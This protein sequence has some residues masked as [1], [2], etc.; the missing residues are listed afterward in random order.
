M[1]NGC[2]MQTYIGIDNNEVVGLFYVDERKMVLSV[3]WS[4]KIASYSDEP[5]VGNTLFIVYYRSIFKANF[6]FVINID[7][8][9][10]A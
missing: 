5:D 7:V 4:R 10:E 3:G 1:V 8:G 2:N 9:F 6:A